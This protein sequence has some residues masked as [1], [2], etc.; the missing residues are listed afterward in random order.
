MAGWEPGHGHGLL[1]E[2]P[3]QVSVAVVVVELKTVET[4][5]AVIAH[6]VVDEFGLGLG[7]GLK[8]E[9]AFEEYIPAADVADAEENRLAVVA[10]VVDTLLA[11]A[12]QN[13]EGFVLAA[14]S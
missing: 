13:E 3:A 14:A 12:Q 10:D 1:L 7:L 4:R 6:L 11:V 9:V 8:L 5:Q 2:E